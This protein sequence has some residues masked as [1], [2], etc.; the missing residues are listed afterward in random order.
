M[1]KR[2]LEKYFLQRRTTVFLGSSVSRFLFATQPYLTDIVNWLDDFWQ[3]YVLLGCF[4]VR[5][6]HTDGH[7]KL[8][9]ILQLLQVYQVSET[10][11]W[12]R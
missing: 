12:C 4:S 9:E 11:K 5:A 6:K 3:K 1:N 8:S 7:T 10:Q 2:R